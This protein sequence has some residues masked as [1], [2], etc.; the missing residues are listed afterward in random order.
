MSLPVALA[1]PELL[2]IGLLVL[3]ITLTLSIAARHHLAKSRRRLSLILRTTIL[4]SLVLAL[5]GFQLVWPVDRLTTV[6][7]VDL[8]ASVGEAGRQS[9]LAFVRESLEER[10][11][12]DEAA[13]V[14]FGAE[15]LVERLPAALTDLDRFASVPA[16]SATDVG[17]AL[18]LAAALFPDETQKR[19]VLV[20]DGNDTTGRGQ[21]EASLAGARGVQI[22]THV[23]GLG[24]ADEVIVQRVHSPATT[25][26][27]EDIEIEVTISSTVAQPASVRLFGDGTQIGVQPVQLKTG[28]NR[29]VF[30][31][32]ATEA[33]FHT[34]RAVVEAENDTFAANNR[35]DSHTIV[36]GDPR[37]LLVA[38][39]EDA[40]ANL[41]AALEAE[42]QDVTQ[43]TPEQMPTELTGLASY[44]SI[45]LADVAAARLGVQ[46]MVALQ[47][48]T[49]DLG[50][51]LVMI[52]GPQSYGAGGYKRTP[53]EE[54]LP[55][56]M[57]VR[58]RQRQPDV[59]LV[60]VIDKSGSMDACHCNT[61]DR[62]NGVVISGI[63]K[64]DIGKEAIMRA[65][66]AL[67]ER[68][69]FGVVSFNENA[70]WV[71]RTAPLG[72]VGDVEQLIGSIR[73]DGQ[74]NIFAGLSEAV[75]SLED[76]SATRRH[77]VL[78]TDGW[79][80]SGEYDQ[81]LERMTAAGITL[82]TVGAGGGGANDFLSELARRGNGRY[83][84]ATNPASI[85]DIFLKETQQVSGQQIVEEDFFPILTSSSPILRGLEDGLPQL[86]GYNGTTVKSA[87]Q[88]V[89]VSARD[90]PVLAQWQ[91]GLGRSVAWTS[92]AH[93]RWATNWVP[94]AGFNRFFSQLVAWTFPGEESEGMEAEFVSDGDSTR[95]RLRSVESDGTPRNFYDTAAGITDPEFRPS[96]VHLVQTAPGV[97]EAQLGTL[98][99]GAYA[100]RFVQTKPGETPLA[101]TVMLVAPTPAEYRLLG[102]NDRLLAALRNATDGDEIEDGA[103]AWRHDL[104]TTTAATDMVPW[105]L[106]LALLLW[107]LDVAVRRVSIA[108]SDLGLAR[109][110][111]GARWQSWRG[112]ARR[113]R[114]VG[115]L[116]A[117]KERAG[118]ARAR[119]A[120]LPR[121][122]DT[123]PQAGASTPK[124]APAT[125]K[126][127]Q[128]AQ[129]P[130]AP[131]AEPAGQPPAAA[132]AAEPGDTMSRL[133]DAKRRARETRDR[134]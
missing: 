21:S 87:A 18:R 65:V 3:A 5:A 2:V 94:W 106:L 45:V 68:D 20:S 90:D 79:S 129:K 26:V 133:R 115:D 122:G 34:F 31:T 6:F 54:A 130:A 33:G 56:D 4:A 89:L 63:P 66:S 51:G 69:E 102:T 107:P 120:L 22:Q 11:E 7:V 75:A 49:R 83:Y 110:W 47:V 53:L 41:R 62:D 80:S 43:V 101:R 60:V 57:D 78:F 112:P 111:T 36:K 58:D 126:P 125:P 84:A 15:A 124:P 117:A 131:S 32:R 8:S 29:V 121:D 70:H 12:G 48:F 14:A 71:I 44:D 50:R 17:G 105:L 96:E 82:S 19:I 73:P 77:I 108:R 114:Q 95:L 16:T 24:A 9:A 119:A 38:G 30:T 100:L 64:V 132:P 59:A 123:E 1:R 55:V 35:G 116:L 23:V 128:A 93:G 99:P 103:D 92:D 91:Y 13:V 40:A 10:P 72:S 42:R 46:R 39:N 113:P 86:R 97:Y 67:T 28:L 52:G 127:A 109:A 61:A 81:L 37:I 85:P 104:G 134:S 118:A 88:L 74:T 27:G 25:R 98:T 76:A